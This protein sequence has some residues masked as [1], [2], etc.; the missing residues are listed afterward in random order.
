M[1]LEYLYSAM[2][3]ENIQVPAP[4]RWFHLHYAL[5]LFSVSLFVFYR[6]A[7]R[8]FSFSPSFPSARRPATFVFF[9]FFTFPSSLS[10]S[11]YIDLGIRRWYPVC[12]HVSLPVGN[13]DSVA[14]TTTLRDVGCLSLHG[15]AEFPRQIRAA[16][17]SLPSEG[18]KEGRN[19]RERRS[20]FA[21]RR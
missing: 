3:M 4:S 5:S 7:S 21:T 8:Y 12:L 20:V 6:P 13:N 9:F 1:P 14:K 2:Q 10:F 15:P 11:F 16:D 17:N 18:R 19:P